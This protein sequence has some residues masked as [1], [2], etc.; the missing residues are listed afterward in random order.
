MF[1]LKRRSQ[2]YKQKYKFWRGKTSH[3]QEEPNLVMIEEEEED[4]EDKAEAEEAR[5]PM[6]QNLWKTE[7]LSVKATMM[8]DAMTLGSVV[9]YMAATVE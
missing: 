4:V 6:M 8:A 7:T 3:R 9:S 5:M 1:N 2:A